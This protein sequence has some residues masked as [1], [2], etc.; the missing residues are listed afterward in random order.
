MG[1]SESLRKAVGYFGSDSH[2][3]Y[4]EYDAYDEYDDRP[5]EH[6]GTHTLAL[7]RPASRDFFIAPPHVFDDVQAIASRLKSDT[8]VIVDLHGCEG[9]LME[10][11]VDFCSGLAYALDGGL[12]RVGERIILL[13]PSS[14]DLSTEAGADAFRHGFF[15]Q[16]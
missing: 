1:V 8:P 3:G 11:V 15:N 12:Y 9:G 16:T 14:M 13:A 10:R 2:E 7:V 4:D 6:D 5:Q